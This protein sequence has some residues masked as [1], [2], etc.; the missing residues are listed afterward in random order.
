MKGA[1]FSGGREL[2]SPEEVSMIGVCREASNNSIKI[3]RENRRP[4]KDL[5][6]LW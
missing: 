2:S 4:R 5:L 1:G 3:S 6:D